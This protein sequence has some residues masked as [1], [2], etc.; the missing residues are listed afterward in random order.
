MRKFDLVI[1]RALSDLPEFV[2]LAGRHVNANRTI[3]SM[4][5]VYPDEEIA[6]LQAGYKLRAVVPLKIPGMPAEWHLVL[7]DAASKHDA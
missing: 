1:S 7:I 4:K 6:Q 3:A 2:R 5:G